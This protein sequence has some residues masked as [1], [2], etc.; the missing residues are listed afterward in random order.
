MGNRDQKFYDY[1]ATHH[2][3]GGIW[4]CPK[5]KRN[6]FIYAIL[7]GEEKF[8]RYAYKYKIQS[9]LRDVQNNPMK[10]GRNVSIFSTD[11]RYIVDNGEITTILLAV[12]SVA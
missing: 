9:V 7:R 3:H 6:V 11:T 2:C 12:G 10:F 8:L 1:C 4:F 5:R